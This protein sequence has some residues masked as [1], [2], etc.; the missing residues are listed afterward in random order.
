MKRKAGDPRQ[1]HSGMTMPG[2]FGMTRAKTS[3]KNVPKKEFGKERKNSYEKNPRQYFN[4]TA[5]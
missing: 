3:R 5:N 2:E 1:E 4:L